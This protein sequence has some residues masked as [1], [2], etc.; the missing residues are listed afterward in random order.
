MEHPPH[1]THLAPN[2]FW[3]FPEVKSALRGQRFQDIEGIQKNVMTQ[4]KFKKCLQQWQHHW[5][6]CIAA[7]VEYFEGDP[8]Q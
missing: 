8:S 4:H 3:L 6:K 2:D 1:S 5:P 7:K